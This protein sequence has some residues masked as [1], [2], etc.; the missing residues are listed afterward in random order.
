[1]LDLFCFGPS[2]VGIYFSP[3]LNLAEVEWGIPGGGGGGGGGI[4]STGPG[5]IDAKISE[6]LSGSNS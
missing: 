3:P 6:R 1:M 5:G 2:L 4:K